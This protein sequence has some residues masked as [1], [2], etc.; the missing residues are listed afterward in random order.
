MAKRRIGPGQKPKGPQGERVSDHEA[1]LVKIPRS[2]KVQLEAL[3]ALRK[4]PQWVLVDAAIRSS[5]DLLPE[6]E[7]EA[8]L[9]AKRRRRLRQFKATDKPIDTET[10]MTTATTP[11]TYVA[12]PLTCGHCDGAIEARIE[13]APG[14]GYSDFYQVPCPHCGK[15][16]HRHLPGRLL[17]VQI[18]DSKP[19]EE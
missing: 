13:R 16:N 11:E 7:R 19:E 6:A 18:A 2:T 15:T 10:P 4:T 9:K 12:I 8:I 17:D 1:L 3:S 14:F 5:I